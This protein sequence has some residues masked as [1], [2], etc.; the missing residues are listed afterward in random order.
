MPIELSWLIPDKI[1]LCLWTGEISAEDGRVLVEELGIALD[2]AAVPVHT[3]IDLSEAR[4][5]SAE[6]AQLYVHSRLP[7]HPCR[8]QIGIVRSTTDSESVTDL[9]NRLSKRVIVR[10]F[11]TREEARN[12]LLSHDVPLPPL[13]PDSDPSVSS[14]SSPHSSE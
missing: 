1:L 14:S 13:R 6:V 9:V 3:V 11:A 12:Y 10:A 4:H 8:G 7:A 5:I 2:V